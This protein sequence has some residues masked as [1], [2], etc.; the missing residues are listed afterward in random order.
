MAKKISTLPIGAK[1]KDLQS[2]YFGK[3]II[4]QIADKNHS[5]YPVN[6]V[7]LITEKIICFKCLD[8]REPNNFTNVD[9]VKRGNN[10]YRLS[11]L[12]KWLNSVGSW[13]TPQHEHDKPPHSYYVSDSRNPYDTESGFLT[14]FSQQLR[15]VLMETTIKV[16][17]PNIY[18]NK[19]SYLNENYEYMSAKVFLASLI[20]VGLETS[21]VNGIA[22]GSKLS[23]FSDNN[24][25]K[26]YSTAEAARQSNHYNDWWLRSPYAGYSYY[27]NH[28][29]SSGEHSYSC[30]YDSFCGVRPLCNLKSEILVSDSP[31]SDGAYK[32]EWNQPPNSPSIIKV[33]EVI[34]S[35]KT[36][37]ISWGTALDPEGGSIGYE[38]ERKVDSSGWTR[39]YKGINKEFT[40]NIVKGWETVAYR[41]K[42]YDNHG[43][44]S[45]YT[46]GSTR[47][48]KNNEDPTINTSTDG[49]LGAKTGPFNLSYS[50]ND[51]DT[52]QTLTVKEYI[53]GAQKRNY[54]ANKGKTYNLQVTKENWQELLNGSHNIKIV[55]EDN[56]EGR[57]EKTFTFSKNETEIELE[58]KTPLPADDRV[59]KAIVSIVAQISEGATMSVEVCNNAFDAYPTWEDATGAVKRNSKIFIKNQTKTASKWGFNV[60]VKVKRN[61]VSGDCHITSI[62]GNYE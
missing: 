10:N 28:I 24:S 32:I 3:P 22:E 9:A 44:E 61:G 52:G 11:N 53:D 18:A 34:K 36:A 30:A 46:T 38:L 40:D 25:R 6:S 58:I 29:S 41:V 42:A 50:V 26:A 60:R 49:D 14:H 12:N 37:K 56:E 2:T 21:Y 23:L 43:A 31:D 54:A 16:A 1:V 15:N 51:E 59:T 57:A 47:T 8:A 62:G 48:V 39:I 17:R 4:F 19:N 35:N 20:E 33:P 5:G 27:M 7:T 45:G 13:Y 55:V